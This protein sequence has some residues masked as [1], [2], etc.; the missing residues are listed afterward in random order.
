MIWILLFFN[1]NCCGSGMWFLFPLYDESSLKWSF[2]TNKMKRKIR[3][4]S[5]KKWFLV[6]RF[7]SI[8]VIKWQILVWFYPK[9]VLYARWHSQQ[10]DGDCRTHTHTD[11]FLVWIFYIPLWFRCVAVLVPACMCAGVRTC[12]SDFNQSILLIEWQKRNSSTISTGA[13]IELSWLQLS[14][15]GLSFLSAVS[16]FLFSFILVFGL[17]CFYSHTQTRKLI[18]IWKALKEK[19]QMY[20]SIRWSIEFF[21]RVNYNERLTRA[22]MLSDANPNFVSDGKFAIF[23]ERQQQRQCGRAKT[24][25]TTTTSISISEWLLRC[26][27]FFFSPK[28]NEKNNKCIKFLVIS[29]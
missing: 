2:A 1:F 6:H 19:W 7:Y 10:K 12:F 9:R 18:R 14:W 20:W 13:W 3:N 8:F 23:V 17:I 22:N 25:K 15:V 11:Y 27:T 29:I 4:R 26:H 5:R 21:F 28:T 16:Y 24:T